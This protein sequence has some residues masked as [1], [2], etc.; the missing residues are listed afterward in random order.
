YIV[1]GVWAVAEPLQ[2]MLALTLIIGY[3]F[4]VSGVLRAI[5]AFRM[6]HHASWGAV[7]FGAILSV[8]LGIMII[9]GWP[10]SALWV[11]GTLISVELIIYGVTLLMVGFG[12]RAVHKNLA[13]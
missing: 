12:M 13:A 3:A 1:A 9:G 5:M 8:I 2:A 11:I 10:D 7:L 6:R 4:L